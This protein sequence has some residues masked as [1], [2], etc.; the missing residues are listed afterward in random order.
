MSGLENYLA[1][2]SRVDEICQRTFE[3]FSPHITCRAGCDA[4]C[5]H[6]SIFAVEAAA[7]T[8]ALR[9]LPAGEAEL[10]RAKARG[11]REDSPCPLLH[12][13]LCL[14]YQS[15]PIICRTHGLPLLLSRDGERTVDF[16]P[17]NF[18]G[19]PSIPG[20]AVIDLE[21]L[22]VMLATINALYLQSFPGPERLTIAQALSLPD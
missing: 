11:A 2:L 20:S 22:N 10:V 1:L 5:R 15:R 4:C 18:Q 3:A 6:L 17:E 8:R 19:L 7:L 16:C 21:R 14:L 9:E 12:D 13:G